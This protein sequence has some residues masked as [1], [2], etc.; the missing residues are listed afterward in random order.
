MIET[1]CQVTS[2]ILETD[3][4]DKQDKFCAFFLSWQTLMC[5]AILY[6]VYEVY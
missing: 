2:F 3:F 6:V 5:A 1:I 4:S